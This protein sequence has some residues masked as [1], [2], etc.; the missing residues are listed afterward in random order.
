[1]DP[2]RHVKTRK[3]TPAHIPSPSS[4]G[5]EAAVPA[6]LP[7]PWSG[8]DGRPTRC[9]SKATRPT[10]KPLVALCAWRC[11]EVQRRSRSKCMTPPQVEDADRSEEVSVDGDGSLS[12]LSWSTDEPEISVEAPAGPLRLRTSWFGLASTIGHVRREDAL[13]QLQDLDVVSPRVEKSM[14]CATWLARCLRTSPALW[15]HWRP[16]VRTLRSSSGLE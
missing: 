4:S 5:R 2:V 14:D 12:I 8:P 9:Q 15:H 13:S 11:T 16:P 10:W 1:M 7:S 6:V 3:D